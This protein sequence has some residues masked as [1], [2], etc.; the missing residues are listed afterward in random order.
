MAA[1]ATAWGLVEYMLARVG[2]C[3]DC[4]ALVP[5]FDS[6]GE[7]AAFQAMAQ[8]AGLSKKEA[9]EYVSGHPTKGLPERASKGK[10]KK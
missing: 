9:R 2:F 5:V 1:T 3:P 10:R 4:F 6:V 8:A 7:L